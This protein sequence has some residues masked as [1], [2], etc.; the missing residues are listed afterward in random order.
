MSNLVICRRQAGDAQSLWL[1]NHET[2]LDP[3]LAV[4]RERELP[5]QQFEFRFFDRRWLQLLDL[6]LDTLVLGDRQAVADLDFSGT[7]GVVMDRDAVAIGVATQIILQ[8]IAL[9]DAAFGRLAFDFD[10]IVDAQEDLEA[11]IWRGCFDQGGSDILALQEDARVS[12]EEDSLGGVLDRGAQMGVWFQGWCADIIKLAGEIV[13]RDRGLVGR[14]VRGDIY[15]PP[16]AEDQGRPGMLDCGGCDLG[17]DGRRGDSCTETARY[18]GTAH[19]V[20]TSWRCHCRH[21][22]PRPGCSGRGRKGHG[23]WRRIHIEVPWRQLGQDRGQ[24]RTRRRERQLYLIPCL[25][26]GLLYQSDVGQF[27]RAS[28]FLLVHLHAH[29]VLWLPGGV[30]YQV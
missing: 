23:R 18:V 3:L 22:R 16:N 26:G 28:I 8:Q 9:I 15:G 19:E 29:V 25:T 17:G 21:A 5:S 7:P 10:V 2:V 11:L 1:L 20:G 24:A 27:D 30:Q 6:D 4:R 12:F 14:V 13:A